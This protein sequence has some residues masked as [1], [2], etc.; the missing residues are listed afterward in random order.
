[1][2]AHSRLL[3]VLVLA[4]ACSSGPAV[5][6][7]GGGPAA[8]D[9]GV[10][11]D[12]DGAPVVSPTEDLDG[13]W[14]FELGE[15]SDAGRF[16]CDA[17]IQLGGYEVICATPG[18]RIVIGPDCERT[19]ADR[20]ITGSLLPPT[21]DGRVDLVEEYAGNGCAAYG[22]P[23][24]I[25]IVQQGIALME[26]TLVTPGIGEGFLS[27][28]DGEWQWAYD[29][30]YQGDG[31]LCDV[32]FAGGELA[33]RCD[34]Y[35]INVAADCIASTDVVVSAALGPDAL[36]GSIWTETTRDG[37]GCEVVQLPHF[38]STEPRTFTA[39]RR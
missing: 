35:P 25:P 37:A 13:A 31:W 28:L 7:D 38:E 4:T 39:E 36:T 23:S 18:A 14:H 22:Y 30:T 16:G 32:G 21:F 26:A 2:R 24:G 19:R 6:D 8:P 33:V 34:G 10:N 15:S 17:T 1:M 3:A 29:D 11:G 27:F 9:A 20:R 5:G 12:G